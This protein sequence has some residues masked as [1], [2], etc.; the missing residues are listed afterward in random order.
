MIAIAVNEFP[1]NTP[2]HNARD[3]YRAA[4]ES[5]LKPA[6]TRIHWDRLQRLNTPQKMQLVSALLK[7]PA[8][9]NWRTRD[10][11]VNGLPDA[12]KHGAQRS[13]NSR[14]DV[15]NLVSAALNYACGLESL[16]EEVRAFEADSVSMRN[17]DQTL[18][19]LSQ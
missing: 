4:Q 9:S 1:R 13:D 18:I 2:L 8:V 12:I 14:V 7:C 16:I 6:D 17:V 10:T 11:V 15:V 3:D 19:E 5:E